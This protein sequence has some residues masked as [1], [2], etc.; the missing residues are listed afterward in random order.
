MAASVY[1]HID[2]FNPNHEEWIYTETVSIF[3]CKQDN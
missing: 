2:E 1:G 3:Y